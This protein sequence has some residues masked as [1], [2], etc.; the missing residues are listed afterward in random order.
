MAASP[1]SDSLSTSVQLHP[2]P[3]ASNSLAQGA[4]VQTSLIARLLG[5]KLL[6]VEGT[7]LLAPARFD[8]PTR[9]AVNVSA[10][11]VSHGPNGRD[12]E[13]AAAPTS[14][15]AAPGGGI[16]GRLGRSARLLDESAEQ[17]EELRTPEVGR[18]I[19]GRSARP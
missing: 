7:V 12:R 18:L 6:E 15:D 16:G 1:Q 9:G 13:S 11:A 19:A 5:V 14:A 4:V 10:H 3:D 2:A 8:Q 17:L